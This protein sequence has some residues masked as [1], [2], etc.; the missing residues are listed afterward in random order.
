MCVTLVMVN[1]LQAKTNRTKE[2]EA[3][4]QC[5]RGKSADI[6]Q[7]A[8]DI[9]VNFICS[10]ITNS[11]SI[12][13]VKMYKLFERKMRPGFVYVNRSTQITWSRCQMEEFWTFFSGNMSIHWL[14]EIQN[15]FIIISYNL[16]RLFD[17]WE[18]GFRSE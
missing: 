15:S 8:A 6:A 10:W 11:F 5:L 17:R 3:A 16:C 2:F 9:I 14:W 4:L 13:T 7:E 18:S 1:H 12:Q